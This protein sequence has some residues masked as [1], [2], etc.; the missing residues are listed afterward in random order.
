MKS[1]SKKTSEKIKT[2]ALCMVVF[3]AA[4]AAYL[5]P[6][7]NSDGTWDSFDTEITPYSFLSTMSGGR[8]VL[9]FFRYLCHYLNYF[10]ISKFENQYVFQF[11]IMVILSLTVLMLT[12]VFMEIGSYKNRYMVA[13]IVLLTFVNP[14]YAETF[15][16]VGLELAVAMI[17]IAY[18]VKLFAKKHYIWS[19]IVVFL[20]IAIYQS[21]VALF[22][23]YATA[24]IW[25][26]YRNS[27][28]SEKET[29]LETI[30]M[31]FTCGIP[32]V[33]TIA[34][35]YIYMYIT[36]GIFS[37]AQKTASVEETAYVA[38]SKSIEWNTFGG[39]IHDTIYAYMVAAGKTFGMFPTLFLFGIIVFMAAFIV[40]IMVKKKSSKKSLILFIVYFLFF[41]Y[42]PVA[43]FGVATLTTPA[44][45][46]SWPIFGTVSV[47]ALILVDE[48][49]T[50]S[51]VIK[52][53]VVTYLPKTLFTIFVLVNFYY[54]ITSEIDFF[55]GNA[56]D[57]QI[58]LQVQAEIERYES[59]TGNK[60][61]QIAAIHPEDGEFYYEQ[62]F[63]APYFEY[64]YNHKTLYYGWS[65]VELLDKVTGIFYEDCSWYDTYP[66]EYEDIVKEHFEGKKWST[67]VPEEQL[68]FVDD[69]LYWAIY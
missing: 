13:V 57:R 66:D 44:P 67:F 42:Y 30:K 27:N 64:T 40:Y 37:E 3:F 24:V 5:N 19:A 53:K 21:Y 47:I 10:H 65:D 11:A 14:L 28:H 35:V 55:I 52:S 8:M 17:L 48:V 2:F 34:S 22:M 23:L 49:G 61:K 20:A 26:E 16:Y 46:I 60:V 32:S 6:T 62:Q 50:Y 33:L 4:F 31:F 68:V 39:R 59:Q 15:V 69:T 29:V 58:V 63:L 12:D 54:I 36:Q 1:I 9:F 25:I 43:I 56:L 7:F 38:K 51:D 18:G 41:N 45:R